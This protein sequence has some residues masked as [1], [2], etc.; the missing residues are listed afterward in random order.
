M[1]KMLKNSSKKS[2]PQAKSSNNASVQE[3][4]PVSDVHNNLIYRK[5][6]H[7]VA[8]VRVHP[9]NIRLL[10]TKETI[11]K[12]VRLEEALNGIDYPYQILSIARPVDLDSYIVK[13]DRMRSETDDIIKKK[14]LSLYSRQAAA[15]VTSGEALERHFYILI[16][17]PLGKNP[18]LDEELVKHRAIQLSSNLSMADL[19][20]TVCTDQE[21]R[22]L[23][24]IF[25]NPSVAAY[26]KAPQRNYSLPPVFLAEEG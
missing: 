13:L 14:L 5:D 17:Q 10:S 4:M 1:L 16:P 3:W 20:S 11:R 8:V 15:T 24:F 7:V 6:R 25:N 19:A 23:L 9:I 21:L 18:H 2:T 22:S 26:E 12:I